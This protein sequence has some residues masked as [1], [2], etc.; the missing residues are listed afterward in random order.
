M[1]R[2]SIL[3]MAAVLMVSLTSSLPVLAQ[4]GVGPG[5]GAVV[6]LYEHDPA[7]D[8]VRL[9]PLE[10]VQ[11]FRDIG[12]YRTIDGRHVRMGRI[13][14]SS[15]LAGM[16]RADRETLEGLGIRSVHDLRTL[17]ER[18]HAP[19]VWTGEAAPAFHAHDYAVDSS[20]LAGVLTPDLDAEGARQAFA[21]LYPVILNDQRP[22][23]AALF[24][25]LLKGGAVVVFHC[26]AGKDRT[27]IATALLL[28]IL[29]VPRETIIA[30]FEMSNRYYRYGASAA[31]AGGRGADPAASLFA[32]LRPEAKAVFASVDGRYLEAIF[33]HIEARYGSVEAY[34]LAELDIDEAELA[35]LRV[36]YVV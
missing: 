16:T 15:A 6:A 3:S 24:N 31:G 17:A 18:E 9:V 29:G 10:G 26:T 11:N 4:A 19:T 27:G 14:R 34:F 5:N 28:T 23:Q 36:L 22:H 21:L 25:D 8:A 12:G 30:D 2:S 1:N 13:Y 33:S 20:V 32:H 35:R 7:F